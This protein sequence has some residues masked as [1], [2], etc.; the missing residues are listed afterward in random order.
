MKERSAPEEEEEGAL[1]ARGREGGSAQQRHA[2]SSAM[3]FRPNTFRLDSLPV[4]PTTAIEAQR[5]SLQPWQGSSQWSHLVAASRACA[6]STVR[7]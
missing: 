2:L 6:G 4:G 1:S 3:R 5:S 7:S